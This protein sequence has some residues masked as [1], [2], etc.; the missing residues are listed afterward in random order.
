[1]PTLSEDA[2]SVRTL[3]GGVDRVRSDTDASNRPEDANSVHSVRDPQ[4]DTFWEDVPADRRTIVRLYL[5]SNKEADQ[6]RAHELC[7][8][9]GLDYDQ[10]RAK[11]SDL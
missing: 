5:R 3:S 7:D 2:N 8:E 6:V 4:G 9:Y 11:A 1:M 10:A